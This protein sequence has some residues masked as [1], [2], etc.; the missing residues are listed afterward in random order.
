MTIYPYGVYVYI[1]IKHYIGERKWLNVVIQIANAKIVNVAI[2]VNAVK[3][4]KNASAE[5]TVD[6][7]KITNLVN[8]V[9]VVKAS[10][11]NYER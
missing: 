5:I 7:Q 1:N 10:R 4:V 3:M 11:K 6:V 2:I 9:I 8:L